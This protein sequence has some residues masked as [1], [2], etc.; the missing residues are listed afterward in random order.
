MIEFHVKNAHAWANEAVGTDL[1]RQI[2]PD[3]HL[4]RAADHT[5]VAARSRQPAG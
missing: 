2:D 1:T 5:D 3:F 4:G